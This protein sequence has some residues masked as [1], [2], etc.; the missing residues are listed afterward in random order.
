GA[1]ALDVSVGSDVFANGVR[2]VA[3]LR[4]LLEERLRQLGF[5]RTPSPEGRSEAISRVDWCIDIREDDWEPQ[6]AALAAKGKRQVNVVLHG[7]GRRNTGLTV[8]SILSRQTQI[9][10]KTEDS[11]AKR[12]DWWF[13]IWG[14]DPKDRSIRVW[15]TEIRFGKKFLRERANGLA[16]FDQLERCLGDLVEDALKCVRMVDPVDSNISRCPDQPFWAAVRRY[17]REALEGAISGLKLGKRVIEIKQRKAVAQFEQQIEG[18]VIG[19]GT[20][21]G[22]P[23][24]FHEIRDLVQEQ[25]AKIS[26]SIERDPERASARAFRTANRYWFIEEHG[27]WMRKNC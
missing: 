21:L 14:I 4:A 5:T 11:R 23:P 8:G 1:W 9:Y 26:R 6:V 18:L 12:K 7:R 3:D 16:T 10:D 27:P 2:T 19:L 17:A 20:L 25:A 15:R 22:R 13:G 24:T